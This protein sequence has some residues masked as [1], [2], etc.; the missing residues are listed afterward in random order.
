MERYTYRLCQ[1]LPR[2]MAQK[3]G[4]PPRDVLVSWD[5]L[6][7]QEM[8]QLRKV[9]EPRLRPGQ[10]AELDGKIVARGP[11]PEEESEPSHRSEDHEDDDQGDTDDAN[12]S[13]VTLPWKRPKK[14]VS[15]A[16]LGASFR[17]EQRE[18]GWHSTVKVGRRTEILSTGLQRLRDAQVQ[19]E[20]HAATMPEVAAALEKMRDAPTIMRGRAAT[21]AAVRA[22]ATPNEP[23]QVRAARSRRPRRS[24]TCR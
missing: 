13:P 7:Y 15:A 23:G 6:S 17:V 12:V 1:I 20:A 19:A 2:D 5:D 10:I 9:Q 21:R 24:V 8:E 3:M 11:E 18:D 4:R 14:G 16:K 22:S